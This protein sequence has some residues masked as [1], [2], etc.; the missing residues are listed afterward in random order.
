M[1]VNIHLDGQEI[2]NNNDDEVESFHQVDDDMESAFD[3]TNIAEYQEKP[4]SDSNLLMEALVQSLCRFQAIYYIS[5][6]AVTYLLKCLTVFFGTLKNLFNIELPYFPES[7]Y[8][9]KIIMQYKEKFDKLVVCIKCNCVYSFEDCILTEGVS[10]YCMFKQFVRSQHCNTLLLK[11]VE[12]STGKKLL[13]PYKVYCYQS[14]IEQLKNR[15]NTPGF[16]A[17]CEQWRSESNL[18]SDVYNGQVWKDFFQPFL[19]NPYHLA[20]SINVD[21]FQPYTH[22]P[23]SVGAIYLTILNLPRNVRYK[24]YNV[25]LIGLIPGPKEP[26]LNI[27]SFLQPLVK[28]LNLL[29]TGVS[30]KVH[31]KIE[32]QTVKCVL[33]CA[34]CDLPASK[35]LCGFLGHSATCGCSKCMKKFLGGVGSKD[36]SGFDRDSWESRSNTQHRQHVEL[37][38][39]APNKTQQQQLES[40]YGCRY[41]VLLELPYFDPVRMCIIDA[42][43]NF[44]LGTAKHIMKNV[45]LAKN[46]INQKQLIELQNNIDVICVPSEVSKISCKVESSFTALTADQLKNW[47]TLYSIPALFTILPET[48]M[49]CWRV[50]VLACRILC[51]KEL[52][53]EDIER[54]DS[55]LVRY[56]QLVEQQ[57]GKESITPNMHM[58]CHYKDMLPDYGPVHSYWLFSY[59]RYNGILGSQPN[60]NKN[61]ELQLMKRFIRDGHALTCEGNLALFNFNDS[62]ISTDM[63]QL[64]S[65]C[66]RCLLMSDEQQELQQII[67]MVEPTSS[68]SS[69]TAIEV[70]STFYKYSHIQYNEK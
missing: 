12:I 45:W 60:N 57:Y 26:K 27:N 28:E 8:G 50:F 17:Q 56:S 67:A 58:H 22:T 54:A 49:T 48:D 66:W 13:Y 69:A 65:T 30:M 62:A 18:L 53:I 59:E 43:H 36:Y 64:P 10:K 15:Y 21:W 5:D 63:K 41:S 42:M 14:L 35:K 25:M 20:L 40:L 2:W 68:P 19:S 33:L 16:A 38:K 46:I 7:I 31:S 24:R 29:W 39:A 6:A 9:I 70:C 61:I 32:P 44:Y 1:N 52:S 55:Y 34:A 23:W 47:V 4:K 37:V 3:T 11:T 51:Q